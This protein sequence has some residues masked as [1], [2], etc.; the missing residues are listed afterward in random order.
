MSTGPASL[1]SGPP[2]SVLLVA[3]SY[4]L[5]GGGTRAMQRLAHHLDA[6]GHEVRVATCWQPASPS[7][8]MDGPVH[9]DRVR[10]LAHRIPGAS[11]NS[12]RATPPPFPDPETT[13]RL[14]RISRPFEPDLVDAY[15][16]IAYSCVLTLGRRRT[17]L[18]L[19]MRNFGNVSA[20]RTLMRN[21]L[22]CSG[23]VPTEC[24]SC[25]RVTYGATSGAAAVVGVLGAVGC[26]CAASRASTP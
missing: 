13:W 25:T 24:R 21:G 1:R 3:D 8:E 22:Q 12:F 4:P 23:P 18:V 2:C 5:V 6:R 14:H 16:C 7:T 15:G 17:P 9:V 26:C 20:R 19:S 11:A 10:A